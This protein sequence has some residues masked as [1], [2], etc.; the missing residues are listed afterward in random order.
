MLGYYETHAFSTDR[1]THEETIHSSVS[2]LVLIPWTPED[3]E[4]PYLIYRAGSL[5]EAQ[6]RSASDY[7]GG[8]PVGDIWERLPDRSFGPMA[9]CTGS[10]A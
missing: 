9:G 4:I 6:S 10:G 8:G 5:A 3:G 1:G 7:G 2:H